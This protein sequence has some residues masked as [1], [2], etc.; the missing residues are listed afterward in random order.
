MGF[1]VGTVAL[2]HHRRPVGQSS[3]TFWKLFRL[4]GNTIVAHS[5]LPLK[6][7]AL[8][9]FVTACLSFIAALMIVVR[10]LVWGGT[11]L[12]W[13]SLIVSM[14]LLGGIQIFLTGIVGLYVGKCFEEA[15]RRP[16]YIVRATSNL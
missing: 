15:K 13:P 4:A 2:P 9:G 6:I 10:V 11:V 1:E 3:Y 5:Q 7:T 8:F 12:G 14:F 16:L